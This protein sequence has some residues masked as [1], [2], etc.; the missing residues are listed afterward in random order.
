MLLISQATAPMRSSRLKIKGQAAV[1]HCICRCVAREMLLDDPS[2][3]MFRK[4]LR[5]MEDFCGVEVLTYCLMTN[6]VHLLIRVPEPAPVSDGEL[7][8]RYA[9]LY[10]KLKGR[11]PA[12]EAKLKGFSRDSRCMS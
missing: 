12:F 5:L 7:V 6:H 8:R 3:E 10:S 9:L 4:H 2:K 1:Y 11:V